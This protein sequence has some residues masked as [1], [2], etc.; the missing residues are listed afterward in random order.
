MGELNR[1]VKCKDE[2]LQE[3]QER[4]TRTVAGHTFQAELDLRAC[5]S[6]GMTYYHADTVGAFDLQVATWLA[7]HDVGGSEAFQFMRLVLGLKGAELAQLLEITPETLSR[8]GK[9]H[10][11]PDKK[12][13]SILGSMILDRAEGHDRAL[14]RL[15]SLQAP[16]PAASH[17]ELTL[18][19]ASAST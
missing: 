19:P 8:W 2:G 7:E 6:C 4:V 18:T 16:P 13:L 11:P 3:A 5:P 10:R 14:P 9:G 1:C 17:A 15:R 12:A